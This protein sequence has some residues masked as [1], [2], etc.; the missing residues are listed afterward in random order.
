[1]NSIA[2]GCERNGQE[3]GEIIKYSMHDGARI[4][5]LLSF[6]FVFVWGTHAGRAAPLLKWATQRKAKC[7]QQMGSGQREKR[8]SNGGERQAAAR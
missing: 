7:A 1:M 4:F 8:S 6:R 2:R 3:K 5:S